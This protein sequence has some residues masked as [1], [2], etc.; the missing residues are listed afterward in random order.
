VVGVLAAPLDAEDDAAPVFARLHPALDI[1]AT[2][3]ADAPDADATMTADLA[4]LGLVVAGAGRAAAPGVSRVALGRPATRARGTEADLA[5]AFAE[6]AAAA[7]GWGGLPAG[8]LLVVAGLTA[9]LAAEGALRASLSGLGGA[10]AVFT[11]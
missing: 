10:T 7:R 5:A 3:F 9:P 11:E 1:A 6:A 8:A 4:G 2:R